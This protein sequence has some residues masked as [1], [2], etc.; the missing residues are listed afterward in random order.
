[1]AAVSLQ[2]LGILSCYQMTQSAPLNHI[3]RLQRGPRP[4][5]EQRHF[6]QAGPSK[7]LELTSQ[8]LRAKPR[9][10]FGQGSILFHTLLEAG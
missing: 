2:P 3:T 6:Y 8:E 1:M 5:G 4:S 9:P 7:G 10:L